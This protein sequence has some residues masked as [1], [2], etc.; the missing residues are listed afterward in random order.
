MKYSHA[1]ASLSLGLPERIAQVRR[2]PRCAM[3]Q[4]ESRG[5]ALP[6]NPIAAGVE[7][8][9]GGEAVEAAEA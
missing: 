5:R 1:V 2:S 9:G 3:S 8:V 4:I 7:A 6:G